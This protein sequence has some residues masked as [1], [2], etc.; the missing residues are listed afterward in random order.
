MLLA[1]GDNG[2][3]GQERC[4]VLDAGDC[5]TG[6][7]LLP[8]GEEASAAAAAAPAEIDIDTFFSIPIV[9][10]DFAV[11]SGGKNLCLEGKP[12]RTSIIPEG[13]VH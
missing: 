3:D 7:R 10:K 2:P 4:E 8:E 13:E 1:A 12:V 11:L 6:A 9:V 5:P